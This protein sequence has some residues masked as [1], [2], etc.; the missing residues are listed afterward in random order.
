M[1]EWL[2]IGLGGMLGALVRFSVAKLL[3]DRWHHTFPLP[4]FIVNMLGSFLLGWVILLDLPSLQL[5]LGVGG[6][7]AL[8]TFSTF[9]VEG[10]QLIQKGKWVLSFVYMLGSVCLGVMLAFLS[11]QWI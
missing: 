1:T 5:F 3:A 2:L 11:H 8:T 6:M 4:T 7:G 10:H 9:M